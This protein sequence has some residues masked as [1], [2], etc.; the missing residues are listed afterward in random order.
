MQP[1]PHVPPGQAAVPAGPRKPS[2]AMAYVTAVAFLPAIAMLY[3][4][5]TVSIDPPASEFGGYMR[6]T[7][8]GMAFLDPSTEMLGGIVAVTFYYT[9]MLLMFVLWVFARYGAARWT[10]AALG[11]LGFAH[12]AYAAIRFTLIGV[13]VHAGGQTIE[14]ELPAGY[15]VFPSI[16]AVLLL[17]ASVMA[18]LPATGRAMRGKQSTPPQGPPGHG[19]PGHGPPG[20]PPAGYGSPGHGAGY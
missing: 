5:A 2:T 17:A 6:T 8:I 1:G 19:Q 15:A 14:T 7:L 9:S 13:E 20:Y 12:Y 4:A 18:V 3:V 11:F 10:T 16:V